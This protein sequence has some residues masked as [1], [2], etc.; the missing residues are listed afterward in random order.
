MAARHVSL[1]GTS[2][3]RKLGTVRVGELD[4]TSQVELTVTL[5]GDALPPPDEPITQA[6]LAN[7]AASPEVTDQVKRVL[8]QF[9]FTIGRESPVTGS[10]IVSGSVAQVEKAFKSRLGVYES[11][12]DG[13][14]RARESGVMLPSELSGLIT[15]I[16]GLDQRRVARRRTSSVAPKPPSSRS[17]RPLGPAELERH[18]GFP[19]GDAAGQTVAIAEFGGGYFAGDLR[20]FCRRHRR[21][22]PTVRIVP[23][24]VAPATSDGIDRLPNQSRERALG[25]SQEVMM[26][27]EIVAGLCP[28][29]E[30]QLYFASF[31][32]KGWIDLLDRVIGAGSPIPTALSVSWGTAEDSSDWTPAARREISRRL[33]AAALLGITVCAATGDDGSGAQM[34]DARAHVQFPASCPYVLSVG[35]TMLGGDGE[36]AW[37]D[38]P[39][40]RSQPGGGSTGGGVSVEFERPEWQDI[41]VPSINRRNI[42]GRTVPDVS[43][44]AG[45]PGYRLVFQGKPTV[46][47]G[48][49]AATPL[50]ASLIA[51]LAGLSPARRPVFLTPLLYQRGPNGRVRGESA[52]VDITQGNNASPQPGRG[53][54]AGP[55]YDAVT[56]WGVPNG[57]TLA[58]SL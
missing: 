17:A 9:G 28:G 25:E 3:P 16:F 7:S 56:G 57:H 11:P 50:W 31:D 46:N 13:Q 32:Q 8:Q 54:V 42:D 48:T 58:A 43:A 6:E 2:R 37:W 51:R 38:A 44:L 35:G 45:Q 19:A 41:H 23:V 49:S 22:V 14:F 27:V 30:I 40:D 52:F 47:G 18:Y 53:Y 5:R 39:G 34:Q 26:D 4:P 10:L 12:E 29:A 21:P 33:H 15:G 20:T 36:V 1:E 24:G 55:G